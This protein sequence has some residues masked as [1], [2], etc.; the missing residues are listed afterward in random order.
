METLFCHIEYLLT[1]SRSVAVP[2][3]GTFFV[4]RFPAYYDDSEGIFFPPRFAFSFSKKEGDDD[5]LLNSIMRRE[6]LDRTESR[7]LIRCHTRTITSMLERGET[8]SLGRI[9]S[10]AGSLSGRIIFNPSDAA[11]TVPET[12]WLPT[13]RL[14]NTSADRQTMPF[15]NLLLSPVEAH[16]I[17]FISGE[18]PVSEAEEGKNYASG[19]FSPVSEDEVNGIKTI[20]WRRIKN[21][22]RYVAAAVVCLAICAALF[23]PRQQ[24]EAL[25]ASVGLQE[26]IKRGSSMPSSDDEA[27][28]ANYPVSTV[29]VVLGSHEK[30]QSATEIFDRHKP[31]DPGKAKAA[32]EI[33][34]KGSAVTTST[35][36]SDES[37]AKFAP[38]LDAAAC[39]GSSSGRYC[40]V[41]ASLNS[42][43]E[44][45][46][47]ISERPGRGLDYFE[48]EGR[49][50]VY[51]AAGDD[52]AQLDRL[53]RDARIS[54]NYKGAWIARR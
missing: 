37:S 33:P 15:H 42:E 4:H 48:S 24:H 21:V 32:A 6:K 27:I 14:R 43:P 10:L 23:L 30:E 28:K 50:R 51:A 45:K 13:L 35:V 3:L 19:D 5:L 41:V 7:E 46:R 11:L 26:L 39:I 29:V 9:G 34:G 40:L 44:A 20:R 36:I 49:Y 31:E 17:G 53:K 22:G 25:V 52:K 16:G 8:V 38:D 54:D 18:M 2:G 12:Y 1:S 47:Y